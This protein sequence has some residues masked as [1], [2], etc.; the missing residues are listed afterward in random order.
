MVLPHEHV[1]FVHASPPTANSMALLRFH[2][3]EGGAGTIESQEAMDIL[4]QVFYTSFILPVSKDLT[5]DTLFLVL[6][7]MSYVPLSLQKQHTLKV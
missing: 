2:R 6:K 5:T 4:D 3:G 7:S 1:I